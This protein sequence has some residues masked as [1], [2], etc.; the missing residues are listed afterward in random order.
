MKYDLFEKAMSPERM[1]RYLKA[2][3]GNRQKA[4]VLYRYNLALTGEMLKIISCFEVILRNR[5]NWK[6]RTVLGID[7]LRDSCLPGGI[8]DNPRTTNTCQIIR[9]AY[10]GL[11][12]HRAYSP[13]QLMAE[14]DFGVWKYMYSAPQYLA[15]RQTLLSI[16]PCKPKS[17]RILRIDNRFIFNE[18]DHINV[19]RNRIAHHEPICFAPNQALKS[20]SY[21]HGEYLR[22][23]KLFSWM[24]IDV[25]GLLV[26]IDC[27]RPI[28]DMIQFL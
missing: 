25:D 1:S 13:T 5:I 17:T 2:C 9:K 26:G 23:R 19:L 22:I 11:L 18:L 16:F 12:A 3:D 10:Q 20:I 4:M 7:W 6:M 24:G 8:F 28:V 21:A 15:T 14:M 27:V